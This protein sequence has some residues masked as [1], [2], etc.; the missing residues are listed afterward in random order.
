MVDWHSPTK[1]EGFLL[2]RR[3][4]SSISNIIGTYRFFNIK[5]IGGGLDLKMTQNQVEL[6]DREFIQ[7]SKTFYGM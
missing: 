6:Y 1:F 5:V 7:Q 3:M 4:T 2:N